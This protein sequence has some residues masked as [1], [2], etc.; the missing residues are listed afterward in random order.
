MEPYKDEIIASRIPGTGLSPEGNTLLLRSF[1]LQKWMTQMVVRVSTGRRSVAE[2][3]QALL[4][5]QVQVMMPSWEQAVWM[6]NL[7]R[8]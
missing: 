1:L 5:D 2:K 7:C 4:G 6:E 8:L 3:G